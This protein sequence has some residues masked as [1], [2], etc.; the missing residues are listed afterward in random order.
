MKSFI[1]FH[2]FTGCD[3]I[4]VFAG[5]GKVK[6]LKLMLRDTRFVEAFAQLGEFLLLLL[7]SL[8]L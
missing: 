2:S 6:P 1:G 8:Y 4:S 3:R 5:G 7:L